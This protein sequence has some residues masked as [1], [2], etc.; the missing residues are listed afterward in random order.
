MDSRKI[1]YRL[2]ATILIIVIVG[3]SYI[4]TKG[5]NYQFTFNDL[6][7]DSNRDSLIK[8][9]YYLLHYN[10]SHEQADWIGYTI[11]P[12][13]LQANYKRRNIFREDEMISSGSATAKDYTRS[14]YDRG[15]IVPAGDMT[16]DSIALEESFYYSNISPQLPGFNRGIW[17][18]LENSVRVSVV[19]YDSIIVFSGPIFSGETKWI[20]E[21]SVSIPASFYKILLLF[22]GGELYTKSYI[23]PHESGLKNLPDYIVSIDKIEERTGIDFLSN[24]PDK[25]ESKIERALGY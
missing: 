21:N 3:I 20:G 19:D 6:L 1:K 25:F 13:F 24:L 16:F 18:S 8:H 23:I 17:R 14:G 2:I 5:E 10:E 15:H 22:S 9:T 11:K 4:L 7:P 12:E